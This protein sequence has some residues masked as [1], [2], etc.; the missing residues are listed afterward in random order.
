MN[1]YSTLNDIT[2]D[3]EKLDKIKEIVLREY[4]SYINPPFMEKF[5]EKILSIIHP[6]EQDTDDTEFFFDEESVNKDYYNHYCSLN[7][8]IYLVTVFRKHDTESYGNTQNVYCFKEYKYAKECYEDNKA[9]SG[10]PEIIES[11][12]VQIALQGSND[13]DYMYKE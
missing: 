13:L 8:A 6:Q 5:L 3:K 12:L 11:R 2:T 7:E 10:Y 9:G 1:N 4:R